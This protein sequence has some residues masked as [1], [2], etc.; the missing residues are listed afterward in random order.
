[1][2]DEL[3]LLQAKLR[4]VS[5]RLSTPILSKQNAQ[6]LCHEYRELLGALQKFT[7]LK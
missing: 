1:M 4:A 2:D 5:T 6:A 7:S 3:R